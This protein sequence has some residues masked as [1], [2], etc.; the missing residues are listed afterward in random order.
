MNAMAGARRETRPTP[1]FHRL[2]RSRALWRRACVLT[3]LVCISVCASGVATAQCRRLST[4]SEPAI[5]SSHPPRLIRLGLPAGVMDTNCSVDTLDEH[6][7]DPNGASLGDLLGQLVQRTYFRI[8]KVDLSKACPFWGG[9]AATCSQPDCSVL[10]CDPGEVPEAFKCGPP[11]L[12]T[13]SALDAASAEALGRLERPS[14]RHALPPFQP[15]LLEDGESWTAQDNDA[16]SEYVDLLRNPEGYTGYQGQHVWEAIYRENCFKTAPCDAV[17]GQAVP[18]ALPDG[19]QRVCK[20]ERVFYRIISGLHTSIT[21]HIARQYLLSNGSW[22]A[23][24]AIY[25]RRV[26]DHPQRIENLYFAYALALRAASKA[27]DILVQRTD[28]RT[29]DEAEDAATSRLLQQMFDSPLLKPGSQLCRQTF[30]EREMFRECCDKRLTQFRAHFRNISVVMD[31]VGCE[32]CRLWGK[33]QFLGMGTALK[34]LF[35]DVTECG[36]AGTAPPPLNRN[37]VVALVNVL[38]KLAQSIR[39]LHDLEALL[40]A[41]AHA[42]RRQMAWLAGV[43]LTGVPLLWRAWW[44]QARRRR[45]HAV[46]VE[47]STKYT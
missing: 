1:T 43:L 3:Y 5:A 35:A 47:K 20:E 2:H 46:P 7:L 28:Y 36:P 8:F 41:Q 44:A 4:S 19:R 38:H 22:G 18:L 12:D 15:Y 26:R 33:L 17:A 30:D 42:R 24:P 45:R 10:V 27:A 23:N 32:K 29:G 11:A 13:S 16:T 9:R 34:I 21:M 6:T 37:E 25:Q 39:T 31:C 14:H 40:S